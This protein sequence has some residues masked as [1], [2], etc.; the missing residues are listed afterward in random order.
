MNYNK[1]LPYVEKPARYT[2]GEINSNTKEFDKNNLNVVFAFPDVYE[3]GMSHL[4]VKI[5]Y[6]MLNNETGVSAERV[7]SPWMD[8]AKLL[9]EKEL[10]LFSLENKKLIKDFDILGFSLSSEFNYTN[11]LQ[12]LDLSNILFKS[13]Q[14]TE[15]APIVIAG[16]GCVFN[17]EPMA[18]FID[19]FIIGDAETVLKEICA[20]VKKYKEN[21][22]IREHK[23]RIE[24]IEYIG[25]NVEGC[26]SPVLYTTNKDSSIFP[27]EK[28]VPCSIKK[29]I[30]KD[31]N[32]T[33]FPT[34]QIVPYI[35]IV[36]DR[37]M[38][39]IMRGCGNGC[40]FCQ[41]G[42]IY[43]PV[44]ER[45]ADV[46]L[47]QAEEL[48]KNTGYEEIG[49]LSLSSSD[50]SQIN[51]ICE[52]L[53]KRF[54]Y[55][56]VALSLP[57][58]RVDSF[59]GELAKHI[60]SSKKTGLTFAPE[61][62]SQRLR[63]VIN[64]NIDIE[65]LYE[66]VSLAKQ[67]GWRLVKL[68]FM[69]GMPTET[70]EDLEGIID[71]VNKLSREIKINVNVTISNFIPKSHTPFQWLGIKTLDYFKYAHNKIAQGLK[72]NRKIKVN[73]HKIET[74]I[75]E[76]ILAKGDRSLGNII[77]SAYKAGAVF[78]AWRDLFS[79][80]IWEKAI[81]ENNYDSSFIYKDLDVNDKLVWDHIDC[82]VSK[83]F[84]IKEYNKAKKAEI[85]K[86]CKENCNACG[87][88]QCY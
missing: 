58:L 77:L 34:N 25:K 68:Y 38:L 10:P 88:N 64:K 5:L 71:I 54:K 56:G 15:E 84:L 50:H 52:G 63:N 29:R 66:S 30:E 87:I 82:G 72:T 81:K 6:S 22:N 74:S 79:F 73:F 39:E 8:M 14:R 78:D 75:L 41:A 65:S 4:G 44:R 69:V 85:T 55:K 70:D 42:M 18:D 20:I 31:L 62:G 11:V 57:S 3:I 47:K 28:D 83:K 26:Y 76:A 27:K 59:K 48:I 80:D 49:V 40:R 21:I 24:I 60:A 16:G 9:K 17:P 51:E 45:N 43:R 32:K 33:F 13:Q 19:I 53:I 7:F 2:G 61:A 23:N 37:A 67:R 1:I 36:H 46:L 86:S 12:I 35:Q